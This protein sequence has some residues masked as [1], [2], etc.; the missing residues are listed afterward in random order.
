VSLSWSPL[1]SAAPPDG[2][3]FCCELMVPP[4]RVFAGA[5]T[6]P[7]RIMRLWSAAD[8]RTVS[9]AGSARSDVRV[10]VA[11]LVFGSDQRLIIG[12]VCERTGLASP[13]VALLPT[14]KAH[15][16][17]PLCRRGQRGAG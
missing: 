8:V 12:A 9:S 17:D 6:G 5:S 10:A 7:G 11:K 3:S 2:P 13:A 16:R 15:R 1:P 14:A 4:S